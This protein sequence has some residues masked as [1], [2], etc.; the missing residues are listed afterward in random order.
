MKKENLFTWLFSLLILITQCFMLPAANAQTNTVAQVVSTRGAVSAINRQK[1]ERQLRRRSNLN[2]GDTVVTGARAQTTLRFTDDTRVNL[3]ASTR[4]RI[5]QY[6]YNRA[7]KSKDANKTSLLIGS[8]R[9]LTGAISKRTPSSYAVNTP[10][11]VIG[12]RGSR[13]R[14]TVVRKANC[15]G[16]NCDYILIVHRLG[17]T[18][19]VTNQGVTVILDA[20]T[21]YAVVNGRNAVPV[22]MKR[23]PNISALQRG[24][25]LPSTAPTSTTPVGAAA[26]TAS[27]VSAASGWLVGGQYLYT[28][29]SSDDSDFGVSQGAPPIITFNASEDQGSAFKVLA[30]YHDGERYWLAEWQRNHDSGDRVTL[31]GTTGNTLMGGDALTG[32]NAIQYSNVDQADVEMGWTVYKNKNT[33]VDVEAGPQYVRV[34]HRLDTNGMD[35]GGLAVANVKSE[36]DGGGVEGKVKLTHYITDDLSVVAGAGVGLAYGRLKS[37]EFSIL[38]QDGAGPATATT[39]NKSTV[40]PTLNADIG[41][42]YTVGNATLE[43]GVSSNTYIHAVQ[44][45]ELVALNLHTQRSTLQQASVYAGISYFFDTSTQAVG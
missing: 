25:S 19:T 30:G 33:K 42:A 32:N 40:I 9:V 38:P 17:G 45:V 44:L 13:Y 23:A 21:P 18:I 4:Y 11:G 24:A 1:A 27:D 31:A 10:V 12:V 15:Q 16:S 14:A 20:N 7:D 3:S 5:D 2:Q 36:F 34:V 29:Q 41:L 8:M 39:A 35:V 6:Q 28:Q 26:Y 37:S 22:A 43:A